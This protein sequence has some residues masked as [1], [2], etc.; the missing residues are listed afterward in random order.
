NFLILTDHG[1]GAAFQSIAERFLAGDKG[2]AS[3]SLL[4]ERDRSTEFRKHIVDA[5][6]SLF[7]ILFCLG[8]RN[9]S[10]LFFLVSSPVDKY[11]FHARQNDQSIGTEFFRKLSGSQVLLNYSTC[12]FQMMIDRKSTRLNSS[13]V[14]ISYAV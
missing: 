9:F 7:H 3:F 11:L 14:S 12:T 4:D 5:E 13:H 8:N 1:S 2:T 6:M 10:K